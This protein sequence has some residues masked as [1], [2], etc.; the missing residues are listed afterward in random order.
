[1]QPYF[2]LWSSLMTD[3][4]IGTFVNKNFPSRP[5]V[6]KYEEYSSG[7]I[8]WDH[9]KQYLLSVLLWN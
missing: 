1:M 2:E 8:F 6:I 9:M 3:A 7:G 5:A 4:I